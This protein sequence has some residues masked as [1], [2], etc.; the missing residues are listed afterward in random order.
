MGGLRRRSAIAFAALLVSGSGEGA[1]ACGIL[2]VDC[3]G[4]AVSI[5]PVHT[6]APYG[7]LS[8]PVTVTSGGKP[9]AGVRVNLWVKSA[10]P[11]L[12]PG[13]SDYQGT[14]KTDASGVAH[15]DRP[16]GWF[17]AELPG[18][19][20]TGYYAEFVAGTKLGK[21]KFCGKTTPVQPFS[22]GQSTTSCGPMPPLRDGLDF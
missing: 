16:K 21:T 8:I 14:E 3:T 15:W 9:V 2:K 5:A 19:T 17:G 7:P 11:N 13:F 4:V 10:G 1:S 12:P 6:S 22:C 18:V 20:V